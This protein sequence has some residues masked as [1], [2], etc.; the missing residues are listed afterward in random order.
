MANA[1]RYFITQSINFAA[2]DF[3]TLLKTS[4][5]KKKKKPVNFF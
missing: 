3:L 5:I 4:K 1:Y 2:K